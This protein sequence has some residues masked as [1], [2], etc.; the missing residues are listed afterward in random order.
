MPKRPTSKPA[1]T[2]LVVAVLAG[3][4]AGAARAEA[5][6]VFA[7][8]S[9]T[10]A[11]TAIADVF[12]ARTADTVTASFAASST[13]ARQIE[14]GAPAQVFL[15]ADTR[16][17]DYLAAR[18]LIVPATRAELLGNELV[19]IAPADSGLS[20]IRLEKG[21]P[22]AQLLGDGRLATGD[23]DHVPVGLYARQALESLGVWAEVEPKLARAQSVRA[24]LTFVER[25]EAPLGI[26]YAT[27]ARISRAVKI[28]GTF[29][30]ASHEPIVYPV[31][32]VAGGDTPAARRFVDFLKGEEAKA[33][34]AGYGF[35]VK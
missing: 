27:D 11:I 3:A 24:A 28:V 2:A 19:L 32:V 23:P 29:S 18:D 4:L 34:F 30:P 35:Q 8:A 31:A 16:W 15:S 6:M 33:I 22:L 13:L 17:M 9:T 10:T 20:D 12:A 14:Q 5:V 21:V 7:T 1:L 26:V 25:G